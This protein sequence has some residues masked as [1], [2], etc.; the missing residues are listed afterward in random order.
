MS[1]RLLTCLFAA[2]AL[3]S[4]ACDDSTG[5]D[6]SEAANVRVVHASV[7][8]ATPASAVDVAVNGQIATNNAGI[9]FG[10]TSECVRVD[11]D[12]PDLEVRVA[13][14]TTM[15]AAPTAFTAG[16]RNTVILSGS[17]A[18]IR[19]TTLDDPATPALQSGRARVRVFNGT[20]RTTPLDVTVT[21]FSATTGVT[22]AGIAQG[23]ATTWYDIPAGAASIRL[24]NQGAASTA[25]DVA[26]LNIGL[27]G[28]QEV[29]WIVLDPETSTGPLRWVFTT[30]CA[31]AD[32]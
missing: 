8:G 19:V 13:G 24:R 4:V 9:G 18:S 30:P 23:S 32:D 31:P 29:M 11:A 20:T 26:Q 17:P 10:A 28:G 6:D 3:L 22:Q 14:T 15:I 1:S 12:S 2:T 27:S 16:G 25:P 5:L 21:P 7:A